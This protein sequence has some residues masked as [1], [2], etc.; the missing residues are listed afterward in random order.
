MKPEDVQRN[1]AER[2]RLLG[3]NKR[4]PG[5]WP[6][7]TSLAAPPCK[8]GEDAAK[9]ACPREVA[10]LTSKLETVE[11]EKAEAIS[12][13]VRR[14]QRVEQLLTENDTLRADKEALIQQRD[15]AY[16]Q[17]D[18][19][20]L[21]VRD[22][23]RAINAHCSCGGDG[24]G[25]GCVACEIYHDATGTKRGTEKRVCPCLCHVEGGGGETS[26]R[27]F[28]ADRRKCEKWDGD[29]LDG[30][31]SVCGLPRPCPKHEEA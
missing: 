1:D 5:S 8:C 2:D 11:R 3:V 15:E 17:K 19:T 10:E 16:Q 18:L 12:D 27:C 23:E 31:Q 26:C 30:A 29:P 21:Q 14:N 13:L 4:I 25:A 7:P 24:P 28:C 22:Y 9:H 6:T 20:D